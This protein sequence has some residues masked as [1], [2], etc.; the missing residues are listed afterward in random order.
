MKEFPIIRVERRS[1]RS[2]LSSTTAAIHSVPTLV[3]GW[4][5]APQGGSAGCSPANSF[6]DGF[7]WIFGKNVLILQDRILGNTEFQKT[8][9]SRDRDNRLFGAQAV[10]SR[11]KD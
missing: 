5:A 2:G 10:S 9:S 7:L 3:G 11:G 1:A 6:F 8:G 4:G